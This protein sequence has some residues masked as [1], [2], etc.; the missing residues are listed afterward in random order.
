MRYFA[1]PKYRGTGI[2]WLGGVPAHWNTNRLKFIAKR[3]D[4]KVEAIEDIPLPYVG[5][6]HVESRTGKL[7][8]LDAE[9]IPEAVSNRFT[10]GDTLFGKLRPYLAK[11]CSP[12]FD[13]LCSSEL[14]VLKTGSQHRRYFLYQLLAEGFI[15]LVDSSTYGA[16]MPRAS[17]EFIGS[18]V[19][20]LPPAVEQATIADFLDRKTAE[21]DALVVKKRA[22][23]EKLK[24]KRSA[25]ISRTV[26]RGLPSE[27]ARAAGLDPNPKMKSSGIE[28]LGDVPKHWRHKRL[29]YVCRFVGG[30][31]PDTDRPEFW[32]GDIPWVSPKDMKSFEIVDTADHITELGLRASATQLISPGTV[33]LVVRSGILRHS[34][35][36]AMNRVPV[37][38]NQD[39]R[40]LVTSTEIVPR[41]LARFIEGNQQELLNEWSKEGATVE[42]LESDWVANTELHLPSKVE[43]HAIADFLDRETAKIDSLVAK[44]EQAIERLQEYRTAFITAAVTG[45]IDVRQEWGRSASRG[46]HA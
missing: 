17:W 26:A 5:L 18:C 39:M 33:L 7:L 8:R 14:L 42:S 25:L 16:K 21:I 6:E 31:T 4:L 32:N 40:A 29:K 28:W 38:L 3:K 1:Y 44:I 9:L 13:G 34:I 23:I 10:S 45:K 12:D 43:Q 46:V 41:Y 19:V 27:A 37:T 20:P 11:A 30:G 22:L 2:G 15:S 35:P 36:V 24:E